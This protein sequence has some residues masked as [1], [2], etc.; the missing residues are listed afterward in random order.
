MATEETNQQC[1]ICLDTENLN[2]MISPCRCSGGSAFVH[3]SCL[4]HWRSENIGGKGFKVCNVCQFE[5]VIETVVSDPKNERRRLMN[6]YFFVTRDVT[7]VFILTQLVVVGFAWLLQKI[8]QYDGSIKQQ[9]PDYVPNTIIYYFSA[10]I[11]IL[12]VIGLIAFLI[13]CFTSSSTGFD[14]SSCR[15]SC[16]TSLSYNESLRI[17][18]VFF[19]VIMLFIFAFIGLIVGV[20]FSV[21]MFKRLLKHHS[22]RLWLRQEANKYVVKD[23]QANRK[24]LEKYKH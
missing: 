24:E 11:L 2:D 21:M 19:Q 16:K 15:N 9:Y 18:P 8:D 5:Y 6:Y 23:F 17:H 3:R 20:V 12:A 4:D 7:L 13:Y 10:L 14:T 22:K 1:R